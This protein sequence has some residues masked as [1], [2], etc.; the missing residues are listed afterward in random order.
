[1]FASG[2]DQIRPESAPTL[3]DIGAMLAGHP[4]LKLSIEGHTDNV[5]VPADNLKLSEA[6]AAAV[7]AAL[8]R[9]YGID[10]ARLRSKGLGSSKPSGLNTTAEGRQNNRRVELVKI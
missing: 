1:L 6:R 4:E 7:A 8:V 2:S 9:D 5:G 3:K 10:A